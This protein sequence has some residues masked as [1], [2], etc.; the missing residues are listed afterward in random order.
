VSTGVV[1]VVIP[2]H[3]ARSTSGMLTRAVNSVEAQTIPRSL[4]LVED[5][6]GDGAAITRQRG[7]EMVT[8]EWVAFLDSDDE[9]LPHHLERVMACARETGAD[10]VYPWYEVVGGRDPMPAHFGRPWDPAAPRL[11]T[12]VVLVRTELAQQVGFIHPLT[13]QVGVDPSSGEDWHFVLG[14]NALG[15]HI[16]HLPERTWRWHHH[17]KNTSGRPNRGDAR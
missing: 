8:T 1:T 14:C 11:T 13:G 10:Y 4:I 5:R 16:V 17:G 12:I 2:Y 7:L 9:F 6:G 15:A 3:H